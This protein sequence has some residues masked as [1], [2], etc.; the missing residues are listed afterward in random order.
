LLGLFEILER[1]LYLRFGIDKKVGS[2][3]DSLSFIQATFDL[4][5][6]PLFRIFG[7]AKLAD[8]LDK[9]GL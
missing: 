5:V 4:I 9:P 1:S 8:Q 3:D 7:I 2:G 6:A